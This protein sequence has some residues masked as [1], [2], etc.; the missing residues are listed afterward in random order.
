MCRYINSLQ[1]DFFEIGKKR[2]LFISHHNGIS[3]RQ[4]LYTAPMVKARLQADLA[5]RRILVQDQ[6]VQDIFFQQL[7][8]ADSGGCFRRTVLRSRHQ[9]TKA[10]RPATQTDFIGQQCTMGCVRHTPF[11]VKKNLAANGQSF[12]YGMRIEF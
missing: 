3:R 10:S 1:T 9:S 11:I 8:S 2:N 4:L 6:E 7:R 12:S 5:L